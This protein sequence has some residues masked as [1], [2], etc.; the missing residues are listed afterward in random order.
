MEGVRFIAGRRVL[1]GA[2]L[3]FAV[4]MLG[5]GA[6]NVLFVPFLARHL[7]ART[8]VLGLFEAAQVIGM[9]LGSSLV[10]TLAARLKAQWIIAAGVGGVGVLVTL[11]GM[12]TAW[13]MVLVT[14][15]FRGPVYHASTGRCFD[16]HAAKCARRKTRARR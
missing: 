14:L 8:E 3:T 6:V 2:L 12:A 10:A 1:F 4:T 5:L 15:F 13:W 16:P 7:N 11:I 9:V